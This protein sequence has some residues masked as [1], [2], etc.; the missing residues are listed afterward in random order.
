M[1]HFTPSHRR[2]L[3]QPDQTSTTPP[4][5][6]EAY[7]STSYVVRNRRATRSAELVEA[8]QRLD[9]TTDPTA[10]AEIMA[11]INQAYQDR[12][13]G[14]LIGLFARCHLGPPYIDHRMTLAGSIIEH[15][16]PI[17]RVPPPFDGARPLARSNAYAYIEIYSDGQVV[18]VRQDGTSGV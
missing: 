1:S 9:L 18:P 8:V 5:T 16:T 3:V 11:W 7:V 2:R 4:Q 17:D 6:T 12:Q 14:D 15:Y 13:G 10:R